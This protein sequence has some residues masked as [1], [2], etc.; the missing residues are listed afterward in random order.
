MLLRNKIPKV[1]WI[2]KYK[3]TSQWKENQSNHT[4]PGSSDTPIRK[5]YGDVF[6]IER[7]REHRKRPCTR[8]TEKVKIQER[9]S[10]DYSDQVVF[11][12]EKVR[13]YTG[14]SN[15]FRIDTIAKP[16]DIDSASTKRSSRQSSKQ[17]TPSISPT[18]APEI[19]PINLVKIEDNYDNPILKMDAE[20][21]PYENELF[22]RCQ[23]LNEELENEIQD[24]NIQDQLNQEIIDFEP[25]L[26][27]IQKQMECESNHSYH[28][29]AFSEAFEEEPEQGKEQ[30]SQFRKPHHRSRLM[31]GVHDFYAQGEKENDSFLLGN[32]RDTLNFEA[33]VT[34]K[35]FSN[36]F[37]LEHK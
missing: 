5:V 21:L 32:E 35:P 17:K 18:C 36:N 29:E 9:I 15:S 14:L 24:Y 6:K 34:S 26:E 3:S 2:Q 11:K 23:N 31:S 22:L 30:T 1:F 12:V 19:E 33:F 16:E 4:C 25:S 10:N 7:F 20:A 37:C 28:E 13:R 27:Q 8:P